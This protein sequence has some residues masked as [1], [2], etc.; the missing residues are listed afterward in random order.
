MNR[1]E[2]IKLGFGAFTALPFAKNLYPF[3]FAPLKLDATAAAPEIITN[4]LKMGTSLNPK[5]EILTADSR[6]ILLNNRRWLPV[7][8]EFHFSRYPE[9]EW[10]EELLKMK[11]GGIDI[12]A[13]YVFWIHHEE[14][15]GNFDWSGQRN[16][17]KFIELAA[18]VGLFSVVR[19]GPWCHGEV[20]NG[21][22]PDWILSQP[23]KTRTDA[24][25]YLEKVRIL[26]YEISKQID[27]LYWK[28]GGKIIGCQFENEFKGRAEHLLNLKKIALNNGIDTPIYTRTAWHSMASPLPLGEIIPLFG[29]YAEGFWDRELTPMP[30]KY[31]D[32]FLFRKARIDASIATDQ[33][34]TGQRK[35]AEDVNK[36]PYFCCEIGGGMI[37]SY[38]RRILVN[39][40]D[41]ESTALVKIGSGNNLQGFYMYHGGTNPIGK[42][43]TLQE[44]Q[45][46]N[47]WND[48][49]VKSY[50][51]QAPL[52]EFG[53]INPHYHSLRL[54]HL[55]FRDFGDFLANTTTYLPE[56][57]PANS[58]EADILRW[59]VRC[60]GDSGFIFVNNYQRLQKMSAKTNVQFQLKLEK[61][62]LFIPNK[63]FT[64]SEAAI[65]FIPFNLKIADGNIIYA[66]AQLICTI[67]EK[68]ETYLFFK[69]IN[70]TPFE[71]FFNNGV[72]KSLYQIKDFKK[73]Q[74]STGKKLNIISLREKQSHS[75]WKAHFQN[76]ERV[77]LT[78]AGLVIDGEKLRLTSEKV[79]DLQVSIFPAP[80]FKQ[81]LQ[82]SKN[83]IFT[84]FFPSKPKI[85]KYNVLIEQ[86]K[87]AESPRQIPIGKLKVAESPNDADFEKAAVWKIRLPKDLELSTKNYLLRIKYFGDVAR[88]YLGNELLTDN[89]YNG[90]PFEIGI[91]RFISSISQ[92]DL[93]LKILPLRKDAPIFLATEARPDFGSNES[94]CKILNIELIQIHTIEL[95]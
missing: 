31:G 16:L 94:I 67:E 88:I 57:Q 39:P 27:G 56:I 85:T 59:S 68:G 91:N 73:L 35:D 34:G 1:R 84:A 22:S 52:G 18:E 19:I 77:F 64:V 46:T 65:F 82:L 95:T 51:F 5:G 76:C 32:G 38:H 50:E 72:K 2:L 54:Q 45:A 70:D 6:S 28:D 87:D 44:S 21:G 48:V 92:N 80:N 43:T 30:G 24:P 86:I 36:Y 90:N 53:Q 7:M 23:Y 10:R 33:L 93:L 49:P 26:Y 83:S 55:F 40:K 41:I 4:Y 3:D 13:S 79:E 62:T 61:E 63:P 47:Y 9:N 15:E 75:I 14:I 78:K 12:V 11:M 66:T 58:K 29:V 81:K 60:V 8:G 42:L 20:R 89:F 69:Q 74:T 71:L 17:R 25:D 37:T